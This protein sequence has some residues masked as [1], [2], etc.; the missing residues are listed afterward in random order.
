[1]DFAQT[2]K[3]IRKEQ[4]LTQEQFAAK[5]NVTRQAVSNW[6]NNKNLPDIAM[7]LLMSE[8]FQVSLD[9]LIKGDDNNMNMSEKLINDGSETKKAKYNMISSL[10]GGGF[11]LLGM[12]L[13]VIKALSV[14]YV[15]AEG[16]LHENFFLLPLGFLSI[17]CGLVILLTVGIVRLIRKIRKK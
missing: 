13:I 9:R 12:L 8:V 4:N 16:I 5:L 17:F 6:E 14:E 15:D 3:N 10:V 7:V 11:V 1:M 2:I